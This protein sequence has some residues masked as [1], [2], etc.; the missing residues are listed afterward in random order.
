MA[1]Y[2]YPCATCGMT[3]DVS[4]RMAD[5]D[6]PFVTPCLKYATVVETPAAGLPGV[7]VETLQ[8]SDDPSVPLCTLTRDGVEVAAKMT[9]DWMP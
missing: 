5:S 3:I 2:T 7:M 6:Q 4:R 9:H 1:L 8:A